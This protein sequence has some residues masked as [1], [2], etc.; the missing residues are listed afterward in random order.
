MCLAVVMQIIKII[1]ESQVLAEAKG[2]RLSV[3]I[4]LLDDVK[5]GDYV[6]IHVGMAIAKISPQKAEESLAFI[7]DNEWQE[8]KECP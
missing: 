2:L 1:D 8:I 5:K 6:L 7:N 3:N 4:D